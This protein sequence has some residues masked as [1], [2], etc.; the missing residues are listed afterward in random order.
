LNRTLTYTGLIGYLFIGTAAV[1]IPS[2]MPLMTDEFMATGLTLAAIGLIFP[3][4]AV[5]GILGNLA[6]GIGSDLAG[7]RRFV[8]LS[9]WGLAAALAFAALAMQWTTFLVGLLLVSAAQ[10]SLSTGINAMIADANPTT[11]GRALNTLHGIYGAGAA[12]SPL[13]IGYF[14][15][16]GLAWRWALGA[17]AIIWLVYGLVARQTVR[18]AAAASGPGRRPTLDFSMLRAGPFLALFVIAFVYN[19]VAVSL[20]GWIAL[21][22]QRA[23]DISTFLS[24]ALISVFYLA[25]TLGRFLCAAFA[26]RLGYPLTLL[27]LAGGV[28]LTYPLVVF[29]LDSSWAVAGVFL[30]GL[31]LSGLFPTAL[32]HGARLYPDQSGTVTGTLNVAMTLG[33]T[34]P[35]VWTGIVAE[36]WGFQAALGVNYFL[37]PALLL[38][39][40]YLSRRPTPQPRV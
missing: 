11:R 10:G 33:A 29:G 19:G 37:I 9:A 13:I 39:T 31:S 27:L 25:L 21:F 28:A 18:I 23:G 36:V 32:A 1:L 30:T 17:T 22:A 8:W 38:V 5:G 40:V 24:V 20:L 4:R 7:S 15:D 6:A 3:A 16:N 34:L 2:V 14:I 12:V 35:P 26:E